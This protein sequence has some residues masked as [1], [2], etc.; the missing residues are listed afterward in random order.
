MCLIIT[1]ILIV[2]YMVGGRETRNA[3][4]LYVSYGRFD[5]RQS[6][7]I[8]ITYFS[9]I[10]QMY[11]M[12]RTILLDFIWR[13]ASQLWTSYE[14]DK[15]YISWIEPTLM[16]T[17]YLPCWNMWQWASLYWKQTVPAVNVIS[18]HF[19]KRFS[20][21][22]NMICL[23]P[24]IFVRHKCLMLFVRVHMYLPVGV[25]HRGTKFYIWTQ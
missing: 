11:F 19:F 9:S 20:I 17:M 16:F 14:I 18:S 8:N 21:W 13:W 7:M 10:Y 6:S 2:I 25:K 4:D 23:F 1:F 15:R 3:N 22:K 12:W 5:I 24:L